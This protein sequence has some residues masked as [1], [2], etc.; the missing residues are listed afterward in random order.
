MKQLNTLKKRITL[1]LAALFSLGCA[2][3]QIEVSGKVVA[4]DGKG[5]AGVI[6]VEKGTQNQTFV[7]SDDGSWSLTVQ[8]PE[9]ELVFEIFP[10]ITEIR[11]VGSDRNFLVQMRFES[12]RCGKVVKTC[13]PIYPHNSTAQSKSDRKRAKNKNKN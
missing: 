13:H 8:S 6:I 7:W 1:L 4:P 12:A 11:T 3:A 9:S 2:Y 5:L 10:Y